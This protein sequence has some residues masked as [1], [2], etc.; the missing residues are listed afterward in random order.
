ML[1]HTHTYTHTHTH[2]HTR[3]HVHTCMH[4][5]TAD[6]DCLHLLSERDVVGVVIK[7]MEELPSHLSAQ[8]VTIATP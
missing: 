4:T 5:L 2:T 7:V 3:A 6:R 8:Q 1:T